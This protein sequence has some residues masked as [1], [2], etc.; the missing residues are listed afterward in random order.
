MSNL[1]VGKLISTAGIK[2]PVF[3][4]STR[5]TSPEVGL[6]IF[7]S[8]LSAV[9]VWSG[10][11]WQALGLAKIEATGGT[12]TTSGGFKI[13]TFSSGTSTFQVTSA[14]A[15]ATAEVLVVAGGG[16]GGG[17]PYHGGGGGAGGVI[18]QSAFALSSQSYSVTVGEGGI[19][20]NTASANAHNGQNSVFGA[21]T[22]IGGGGGGGPVGNDGP[23]YSGG[24]G[25][26]ASVR[27]PSGGGAG[28]PGQG[29]N[30]GGGAS[31]D[32]PNYGAGGGGGAGGVGGNG[33]STAGGNG[34]P[35]VSYNIS[36]T[37][38]F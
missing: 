10:T 9:E 33:T 1:N 17:R 38:T 35:G 8:T 32:A 7:N 18:Y 34:G 19:G 30:G 6:I 15:N 37:S 13:H 31:P 21:L 25:G 29:N 3:T 14:P 24:S 11:A 5:P 28:T 22:A 36:G 26:G 16:G 2:L 4:S 23:G 27:Q 20:Y 12:I